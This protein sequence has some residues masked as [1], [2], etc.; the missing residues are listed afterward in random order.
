MSKLTER[1]NELAST[2]EKTVVVDRDDIEKELRRAAEERTVVDSTASDEAPAFDSR[3]DPELEAILRE[4][5]GYIIEPDD[6]AGTAAEPEYQSKPAPERTPSEAAK[7]VIEEAQDKRK[8]RSKKKIII[9]CAA[10]VAALALLLAG[11]LL[12]KNSSSDR[13]YE[14]LYNQAQSLYYDGKYDE[15]L[16]KLRSAMAINKTDDCLLLMSQCYEAKYDYVNAIAILESS[17]SDSDVIKKRIEMLKKAKEAYDSGQIVLIG[18]EQYDIKTTTVLDLS[19]KGLRSGRLAD[20]G[21]LTELTSLKL[22]DN[23]IDDLSFLTP[24]EK[25]VSLDLSNNQIT[26]ITPLSQ[27]KTLRTLHL[28]N[29]DIKDFTPLYDLNGLTMLTIGGIEVRQSQIKEL[30][31]R[32]PGCLIYNDDASTDIVEVHL[33]GKTFKSDVTQLDL[34][35]CSITDLSPLSVCTSLEE[36]DLSDNYISDISTLLDLPKLRVLDLSSNMISDIRPLMSITT[37]EH[38]N[39][40]DNKITSV[41]ALSELKQLKELVLSGNELDGTQGLAKLSSL[42]ILGLKSTGITDDDLEKLYNLKSLASLS[43]ENNPD[44]TETGVS[45]LKR[46]LPNCKITHS[47]LTK[48]ITLGGKE[49][50]ATAETVDA[51]GLGI[52]DIS[53]VSGFKSVRH[54]DL[55]N[56]VIT[57]V[58]A[59]SRLTTLE[60]LDLSDNNIGDASPLYSLKNLRL[61]HIEKNGLSENQITALKNALPNCTIIFE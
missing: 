61:L 44:L 10:V 37:L 34:S 6:A 57:S 17:N 43:L 29:N 8:T 52:S 35:G 39:L 50:S 45:K 2:E 47:E 58:S 21:K 24:L 55:S 42:Q 4:T 7:R 32:L 48:K 18:D 30:K 14:Q 15:A 60:T 49:F 27:L 28:D 54:L 59:L 20:I 33:G 25:L 19:G 53:A 46:K 12:L 11:V 41:T 3:L 38:L 22:S 40:A 1:L 13:E 16:E 23:E 9:V 26:D 5:E 36:L 51:A 56:N 31:T